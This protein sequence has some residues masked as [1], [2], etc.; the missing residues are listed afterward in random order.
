[1]SHA[2]NFQTTFTANAKV[3][4]QK[5]LGKLQRI[6]GE[7]RANA[8]SIVR[9][10]VTQDRRELVLSSGSLIYIFKSIPGC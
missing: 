9:K 10:R 4:R 2:G 1:V 7:K 8:C 5:S 6:K 3:L